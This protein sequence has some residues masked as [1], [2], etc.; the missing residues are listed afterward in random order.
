MALGIERCLLWCPVHF[1][2]HADSFG[3]MKL[4]LKQQTVMLVALL[5]VFFILLNDIKTMRQ[6]P[7]RVDRITDQVGCTLIF[8][9][10]V[11]VN[12]TCPGYENVTDYIPIADNYRLIDYY[13]DLHN[14]GPKTTYHR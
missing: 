11:L 12:K 1:V 3:M 13:E 7:Q 8:E 6:G 9:D 5:L 4:N 14:D 10:L 2:F